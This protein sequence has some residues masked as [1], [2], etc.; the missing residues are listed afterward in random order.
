MTGKKFDWHDVYIPSWPGIARIAGWILLFLLLLN[1]S[2][3]QVPYLKMY[4]ESDAGRIE[5]MMTHEEEPHWVREVPGEFP[6]GPAPNVVWVG[7]SGM[8]LSLKK[9]KPTFLP[10]L[11]FDQV[12]ERYDADARVWM[13]YIQAGRSLDTFTAA[14]DGV[15]RK[16]DAI[17]LEIN[18]VWVF[19]KL[20]FYGFTN[21]LNGGARLW[22]SHENLAL[23]M[24]VAAPGNHLWNNAGRYL[25]RVS[26]AASRSL[27]TRL[28]QY[29]T[30]PGGNRGSGMDKGLLVKDSFSQ[31][32]V[33]WL[34]NTMTEQ[35]LA[36]YEVSASPRASKIQGGVMMH[37]G[38]TE[39]AWPEFLFRKQLEAVRD[40]GIPAIIYLAP[41]SPE[42]IVSPE[43][44]AA[45]DNIQAKLRLIKTE[46]MGDNMTIIVDYPPEVLASITQKDYIHMTDPGRFPEFLASAYA[47]L[48]LIDRPD[49]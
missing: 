45:Y 43:L 44:R 6:Q 1:L 48:G 41:V 39:N 17:F 29:L 15:S 20:K 7:G 14:L 46:Y 34:R 37:A 25:P 24:L 10:N 32:P 42:N 16:P 47:E 9:T 26:P 3:R 27:S 18:P 8:R 21:L 35:D 23:Q 40:S 19:G 30:R 36:A 4:G 49:Q 33:F 13:Y 22:R 31:P 2:F 5:Y 12:S 11:V 38:T 28:N